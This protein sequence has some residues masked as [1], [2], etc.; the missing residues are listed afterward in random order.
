MSGPICKE[1]GNHC[2]LRHRQ[3]DRSSN[4]PAPLLAERES[5]HL[6]VKA[7]ARERNRPMPAHLQPLAQM[8]GA[9]PVICL[10]PPEP[11]QSQGVP[12]LDDS[13]RHEDQAAPRG[14]PPEAE[15]P[16]LSRGEREARVETSEREESVLRASHVVRREKIE[17]LR[18]RQCSTVEEAHEILAAFR[19]HIVCE[20]IGRIA[21][22]K[23]VGSIGDGGAKATEPRQRRTAVVVGERQDRAVGAGRT[24]I[25]GGCRTGV[26]LTNAC[27]VQAVRKALR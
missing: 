12:M 2:D 13:V 21:A 22:G 8:M 27:H 17:A 25:P 26:G 1:T 23:C 24:G 16:V 14:L 15:L 18:V 7:R 9:A 20:A 6:Q 3:K 5:G 10:L 11:A 19:I 4:G